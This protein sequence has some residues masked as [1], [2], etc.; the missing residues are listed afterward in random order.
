MCR[1]WENQAQ[2]YTSGRGRAH[3]QLDLGLISKGQKGAITRSQSHRRVVHT[4]SL[5]LIPRCTP[6]RLKVFPANMSQVRS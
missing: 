4:K 2:S 1:A 6:T 5:C 3:D